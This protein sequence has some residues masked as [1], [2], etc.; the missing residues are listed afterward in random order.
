VC[1]YPDVDLHA[2]AGDAGYTHKDGSP[3]R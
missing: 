1:T 2:P 3:Y